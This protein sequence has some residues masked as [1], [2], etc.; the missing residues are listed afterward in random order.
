MLSWLKHRSALKSTAA[1]LYGAVV[2]RARSPE[3]YAAMG[4]PD[5]PE[6]RYEMVALH[7]LLALERLRAEGEQGVALSRTLIETF[8]A[9]M[10]GSMREMGVGDLTVPKKVKAAAAGLYGRAEAIR[11][12]LAP[13]AE[14]GALEAAICRF[15]LNAGPGDPRASGFARYIRAQSAGLSALPADAVLAGRIDFPPISATNE[16]AGP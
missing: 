7:L 6:G 12:A 1:D 8:I 16:G 2:A 14:A 10:D 4:I 11:G 5:T 9:D 3:F 13:D 15:T